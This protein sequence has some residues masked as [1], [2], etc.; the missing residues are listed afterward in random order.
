MAKDVTAFFEAN[1]IEYEQM[2]MTISGV[3]RALRNKQLFFYVNDDQIL[4]PQVMKNGRVK[5]YAR[6]SDA[7]EY[8]F[9]TSIAEGGHFITYNIAV[10]GG[11]E[12]KELHRANG[13]V[14]YCIEQLQTVYLANVPFDKMEVFKSKFRD[15]AETEHGMGYTS[16]ASAGSGCSTA[17]NIAVL[18]AIIFILLWIAC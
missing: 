2:T 7:Q 16:P 17:M 10:I 5:F 13:D 18:L 12:T 15:K 6:S 3:V 4:R 8:L 14:D 9:G 11:C 1:N